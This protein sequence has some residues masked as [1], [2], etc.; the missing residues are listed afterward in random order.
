MAEKRIRTR[1]AKGAVAVAMSGGVDSSLAAAILR[2]RGYDLIGITFT[3]WPPHAVT[4]ARAVAQDLGI[5]HHVVDLRKTFDRSVV[6]RFC[7]DYARGLTPNP[8]VVCNEVIKFGELASRA[9]RLG[10]ARIATGH[11]VR[12]RRDR[13]TGRMLLAAGADPVKDQSYFLCRVSSRELR[14]ALFPLGGMT[15]GE[16]RRMAEGYDLRT[17]AERAS[18]D[19]CF[20]RDGDYAGYIRRRTGRAVEP[21]EIVDSAGRVRGRHKGTL[22]YTIGQRRGLGIAH[23]EPLY[24][25][26]IDAR[27]N[28]IVVGE[29]REAM[30]KSL[31]ADRLNWIADVDLRRPL[32]TRAKIR[33]NA[34]RVPATVTKISR[35][36]VRVDFDAPQMA[37]T[38]GQAVVFYRRDVVLGGSWIVQD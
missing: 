33:Y 31:V 28:R 6:E 18:Q 4:R 32:R 38:P 5:P 12:T 26:A 25:I 23:R 17:H 37:P 30:R 11:Y 16:V 19:I 7:A 36:R 9:R 3:M 20:V 29:R 2:D 15:K 14:R 22:H 34:A 1:K 10:A 8:C 27:H 24:V 21:G 35:D 13:K